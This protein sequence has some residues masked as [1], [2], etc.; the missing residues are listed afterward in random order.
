M[1]E[2]AFYV[3]LFELNFSVVWKRFKSFQWILLVESAIKLA[4]ILNTQTQ[5]VKFS[6]RIER[7]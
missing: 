7:I 6:Q 4:K 2:R 1:T 5:Q 3:L